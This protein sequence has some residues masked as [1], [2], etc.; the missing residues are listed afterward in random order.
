MKRETVL[1]SNP[2]SGRGG[3]N[4]VRDEALFC[5]TL[6]RRGVK[7]Q[8]L[9]TK[10]P[11]DAERY[12]A[13]SIKQGVRDIIVS[14][15]D[16]TINEVLQGSVGSDARIAVWPRGTANVFA[17]E[18]QLPFDSEHAA[19][20]I[21][22][23]ISKPVHIGRATIERTGEQ[24]FFF[25]MAGIGLD[26]SIV[27]RVRP[28]LKRRVGEAAFWYSGLGHLARWQPV[29][30]GIEI[31]G[32]TLDATFAAIGKAAH[33]G[34]KLAITPRA[35]LEK[36]E[37]EICI[38]NSKSRLHF[39]YLLSQAK[40]RAGVGEHIRGVQFM[41]ATRAR[42]T[43]DVMVQIDGELTGELPMTFEIADSSVEIIC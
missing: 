13:R 31:D 42:V 12:A 28:R 3:Q 23:G 27:Q 7:I 39:L 38:V 25:L 33:Y 16:G 9:H 4:S 43:G 11:N 15:G 6:R 1:I 35:D 32:H 26:A 29:P 2:N 22:R 5:E 30:F 24:R 36:P 8:V 41:R 18:L 10:A 14:G 40:R 34:G 17:R 19:K 21:A 20:V 37:F